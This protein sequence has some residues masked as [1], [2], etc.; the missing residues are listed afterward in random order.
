[1]FGKGIKVAALV[2]SRGNSTKCNHATVTYSTY[3]PPSL[4]SSAEQTERGEDSLCAE[5]S[6]LI[7]VGV[8]PDRL[9]SAAPMCVCFCAPELSSFFIWFV[10]APNHPE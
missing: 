6:R 8:I 9:C 2:H 5:Q 10:S 4:Q 1:M 3:L 7:F